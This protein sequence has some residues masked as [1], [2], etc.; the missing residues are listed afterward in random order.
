M[1]CQCPP[2]FH[3]ETDEHFPRLSMEEYLRFSDTGDTINQRFLIHE[4]ARTNGKP[5]GGRLCFHVNSI[6][7]VIRDTRRWDVAA[8]A[9]MRLNYECVTIGIGIFWNKN[10]A[11]H[12]ERNWTIFILFQSLCYELVE[13][14]LSRRLAGPIFNIEIFFGWRIFREKFEISFKKD[15]LFWK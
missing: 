9:I 4:L 5:T 11:L 7:N 12:V 10:I 3:S 14:D 13:K 1:Q 2:I 15:I 6:C 8:I